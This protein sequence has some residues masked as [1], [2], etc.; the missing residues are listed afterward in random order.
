MTTDSR[1]L[2]VAI[3][4]S[5]NIGTDLLMKVLRSAV[6]ECTMFA[7]RT[8]DSPG[9]VKARELGVPISD[10]GIDAILDDPECCELVFDATSAKAH[11]QHWPRLEA[12]GKFVIDM[13]PSKVGAMMVPAV[14]LSG[15]P[16]H[17]NV[18]M[19]SCGGQASLPLV[20]LIGMTQIEVE[21]I[22]VVSSIASRS[23]GPAT[24]LNIDE[25]VETTE[26]AIRTYSGCAKAKTILILNPAEP[27]VHMQTTVSAKM[28]K[29]DLEKLNE[30]LGPMVE[31]I[32]S[33]V[34]GYNLIVPPVW[35]K[36]RIAMTVRV[37]GRGDFLPVYAG[38]LDIINC[39][40]IAAAE[41]YAT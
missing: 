12:I 3:L 26:E 20:H 28:K 24:R 9:M 36:N 33:Y 7:G 29:P 6:L 32:K 30:V 38:N 21:Y 34:P 18:N 22:E 41:A 27:C 4:G 10:R 2:K 14:D 39:A 11:R 37:S 15:R 35:E 31:R 1:K 40:A 13:T 19:I 8:Q 5:G 25:Y 23:A 17:R 16:E